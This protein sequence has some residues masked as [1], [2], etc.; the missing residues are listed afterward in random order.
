MDNMNIW[1]KYAAVPANAKKTIK[2]GRLNGF[3]DINPMW[4]YKCLTEAFGPCGIG[5]TEDIIGTEFRE[6]A[7]G[8]TAVFVTVAMKIKLN[9]E[10]SAPITGVG[11]SMFVTAEKS[12][13]RTSDEAVKMAETD[14]VS[15][16]CKKLGFGADVYWEAGRTKNTV[17][18]HDDPEKHYCS[19]CG[20]EING[21]KTKDQSLTPAQVAEKSAKLYGR[22]LCTSCAKAERERRF[23]AQLEEAGQ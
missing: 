17:S 18:P 19:D 23:N 22:K 5:W 11:G 14:A 16:A 1:S 9:G 2:G 6:G 4:R 20:K 13:L 3:T 15:V 21:I 7:N 8:E 10:W 12:G